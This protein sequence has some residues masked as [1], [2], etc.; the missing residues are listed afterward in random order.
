MY[1]YICTAKFED[2]LDYDYHGDKHFQEHE[3]YIESDKSASE[4]AE[5]LS[6]HSKAFGNDLFEI[7]SVFYADR[8]ITKKTENNFFI[9]I[10]DG[11]QYYEIEIK[12]IDNA[13]WVSI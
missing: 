6:E 11:C 10:I 4:I 5:Y 13:K 3:I 1:S 8:I 12:R 9:K 7:P 2:Q